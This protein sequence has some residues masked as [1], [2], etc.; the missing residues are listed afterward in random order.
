MNEW[1]IILGIAF[2]AL[3]G[4]PGLFYPAHDCRG[5]QISVRL[6]VAGSVSGLAGS[7]WSLWSVPLAGSV[8]RVDGLAVIFLLPIFLIPAL[9][10]IYGLEYWSQTAHPHNGRK[11]RLFYGL[12]TAAL[13][14]VA[15]AANTILFLISWEVMAL[16]AFFLVT[17]EDEDRAVREAGWLYLVTTHLSTLCLFALFALM[18]VATGSYALGPLPASLGGSGTVTALFV[19]AV[20]AFGCKAGLMPMHIWLPSAHAMTPSHVSALMSGVLIK[21]GIYGLIRITSWLP[22][23]PVWWGGLLLVMGGVSGVLG[24]VMALGQH[25]LKRLLAYHSI[26][27]IGIIVMGVGLALVGRSLD[28]VEWVVLGMAGALLHVW[29]HGL[30]KALLFLS[31]GA[32]IHGTHS[33]DMDHMGGLAR[34]MP[35]T[36]L[37]FAVGAVAICGLPPLNGFVSELLIYLGA[38]RALGIGQALSWPAAAFAAPVLALIGALALACFVKAFGSVFL[39]T[40][41]SRHCEHAREVGRTM[42]VPMAVLALLCLFIGLAPM[43]VAP[44]LDQGIKV[45][46]PAGAGTV[47]GVATL[48]PLWWVSAGSLTL[49]VLLGLLGLG[50]MR[51]ISQGGAATGI[52]WDCGYA[53]PSARMQYTASS[54][55]QILS[56]LFAW[57]QRPRIRHP[58]M[59]AV[60]M[61]RTSFKSH[62]SDIMLDII[63]K[64][65]FRM[66]AKFMSTFRF[67]QAGNI[68][69]YLFYI[70][71]FLIALLLWK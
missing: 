39:G 37:F 27:N 50:M 35:Y 56:G 16:S 2:H 17:T 52:T 23:P 14:G 11:V 67:I 45:C 30:F 33:R 10:S 71:M 31:A 53:A 65:A 40:A 49:V 19:L 38:F 8:L 43:A 22:D 3:S 6:A 70:V 20:L 1:L 57:V 34:V 48:A 5:Q 32:V 55:A 25:D 9:G 13:A 58:D 60:F 62:V 12:V 47:P 26:E 41:R 54:F 7:L 64:P 21:I 46:L 61:K 28:C 69:A 68:H 42:T 36:A 18:R 63:L 44:L 51:R 4:V 29:N 15:V 24:V 66:G 59:A